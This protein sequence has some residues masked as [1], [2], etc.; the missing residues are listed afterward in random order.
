M[1][2]ARSLTRLTD[3]VVLLLEYQPC[4]DMLVEA[5]SKN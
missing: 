5:C 1:L 4:R 3:R 2:F